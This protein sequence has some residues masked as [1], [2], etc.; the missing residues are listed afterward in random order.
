MTLSF[1]PVITLPSRQRPDRDEQVPLP[2]NP[3]GEPPGPVAAR[4]A[5]LIGT[6]EGEPGYA[7]RIRPAGFVWFVPLGSF[8]G[9]GRR[10]PGAAVADGV[11]LAVDGCTPGHIGQTV[12]VDLPKPR[13][14]I[15]TRQLPRFL[16]LR[17]LLHQA[18]GQ[19]T[20]A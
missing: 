13:D 18:I 2:G 16:E 7:G 9:A 6:D 3:G 12:A 1:M 15:V 5:G 14:Q 10:W 11:P 20:H 17:Y 8:G 19:G 4:R